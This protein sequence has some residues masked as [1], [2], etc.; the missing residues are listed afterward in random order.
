MVNNRIVLIQA[1]WF[2]VVLLSGCAAGNGVM[3]GDEGGVAP[4]RYSE[5]AVVDHHPSG[6][7][8]LAPATA[9]A[10]DA[11]V[12]A[13]GGVD[14]E[15]IEEYR[16]GPQDLLEIQV[17]GVPELTSTVRVNSRGFVSL[18]LIGQVRA[19]GLTHEE[20]AAS[21]AAE[22][23]EEYLQD[24]N[25][26]IFIKEYTSQRVTIEGAVKQPGIYAIHGQTTLL[27]AIAIAQGLESLADPGDIKLFRNQPS[28][29]RKVLSFSLNQIRSGE[30]TDPLVQGN[31]IIVVQTSTGKSIV[32]G[33]TDTIRGIIGFRVF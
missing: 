11:R 13:Q 27:Q 32:K 22:L 20:L 19:A 23:S 33:I 28:G 14:R 7:N 9:D 21:I 5:G 10:V 8:R 24:P 3:V 30:V 29:A 18:P 26:N 15:D 6:T 2:S 31:D 4:A 25:V 17:F 16:I 12:S 1:L